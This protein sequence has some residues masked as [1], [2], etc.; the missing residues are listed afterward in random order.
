M[1][2]IRVDRTSF[3]RNPGAILN[4]LL[5][6][7]QQ[8]IPVTI[9]IVGMLKKRILWSRNHSENWRVGFDEKNKERE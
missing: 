8:E 4:T 3:N 2:E 1:I 7:S 5:N 9:I 6:P